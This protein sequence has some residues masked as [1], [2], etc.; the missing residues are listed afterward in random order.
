MRACLA[1]LITDF[2]RFF[3]LVGAPCAIQFSSLHGLQ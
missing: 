2:L 3:T 1:R